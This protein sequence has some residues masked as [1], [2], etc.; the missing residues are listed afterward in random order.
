MQIRKATPHD[1]K[2]LTR[3]LKEFSI[4]FAT[5]I[6]SEKQTRIRAYK[7]PNKWVEETVEHYLSQPEHIV[8]VADEHEILKGFIEGEVKE[9]KDKVYDREGYISK[10]FMEEEYQNSGIGKQLFTRL[11]EEFKKMDCTHI[12]LD[13]HLEN[14]QAIRIYEHMG[15]TKRLITF[16]K[17]LKNL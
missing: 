2:E 16:F 3:L 15:F 1:K 11:V 9:H 4:D 8:F 12:G 6:L 14:T 5:K 7:N 10:W 17:P 13:T